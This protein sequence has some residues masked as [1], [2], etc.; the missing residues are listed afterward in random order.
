MSPEEKSTTQLPPSMKER[1]AGGLFIP[2]QAL[3]P[4]L[5]SN[6][7]LVQEYANEESYRKYGK[8]LLKVRSI[9]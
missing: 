2:K 6:V 5:R 3:M 4:F 8:N 1:D 9:F 7:G